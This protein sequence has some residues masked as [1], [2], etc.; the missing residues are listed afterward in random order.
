MPVKELARERDQRCI[1]LAQAVDN[2]AG[3]AAGQTPVGRGPGLGPIRATHDVDYVVH[4]DGG[5]LE[6]A[7]AAPRCQ[8]QRCCRLAAGDWSVDDDE[9]RPLHHLV[10]VTR[11]KRQRLVGMVGMVTDKALRASKIDGVWPTRLGSREA[12]E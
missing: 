11:E 10:S 4:F 7:S 1:L 5:G 8:C 9:V 3:Q 2:C 12:R 6:F